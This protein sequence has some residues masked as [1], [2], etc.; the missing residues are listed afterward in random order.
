[1]KKKCSYERTF[2]YADIF[3][4]FSR[5]DKVQECENEKK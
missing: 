4:K 2:Y 3:Y 5:K 1:M